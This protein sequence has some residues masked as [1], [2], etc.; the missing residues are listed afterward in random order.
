[1]KK[2]SPPSVRALVESQIQRPAA[3]HT[4][5]VDK[6]AKTFGERGLKE[7]S[8]SVT[9]GEFVFVIGRTGSGKTTLLRLLR[10]ELSPEKGT[11][12]IGGVSLKNI[13]KMA[14]R[15]QIGFVSQTVDAIER[16]TVSENI[17]YPLQAL[18]KDP[19]EIK[20]RVN[21]LLEVFDLEHAKN[22]LCN[23]QEL[24]G[25]ERQRMAIARAIAHGPDLLL[26]DEPTG[27]L[28]EKTTY[29]VLK[30]LNQVAMIGTTVLCVTHDPDIV[31]LMKRRVLV[32]EEGLIT[33]DHI[34]GYQL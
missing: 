19:S 22:R 30:T 31:N 5:I 24:S 8:F 21:T 3:G 16:L 13:D 28:D 27:N 33:S 4:I 18:R 2:L 15:R 14:Y 10:G 9:P 34:G 12:T 11:I 25:G 29:G 1:M 6:V 17:A 7:V 23:D 26:C 20:N 32:I